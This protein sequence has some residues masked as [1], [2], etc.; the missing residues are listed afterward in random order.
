MSKRSNLPDKAI[1]IEIVNLEGNCK[2]NTGKILQ[3]PLYYI[4]WITDTIIVNKH[5]TTYILVFLL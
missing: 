3:Q 2:T 1:T 5:H 4:T